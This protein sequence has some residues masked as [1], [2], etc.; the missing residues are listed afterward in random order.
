M[1]GKMRRPSGDWA[2]DSRAISWVGS[3]VMSRPGKGDRALARP[4]AAEDRHHQRRLAGAVGADQRDDLALVHV[5]IDAFERDDVAVIGLDAADA[6]ERLPRRVLCGARLLDE[7]VDAG[8]RSYADL[9]LDLRDL[10][11][12]D[13]EIGRDDALGRCGPRAACRPKSW[14]R[15]RARPRGRRSPSPPTCRAR[16]AGSRCRGPRG[17]TAAAR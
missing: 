15:S 9:R 4:R 16:S 2:I 7:D 6:E 1:R 12:L 8:D 3:W 10:L 13:A 11:V 5:E 14:C 17:S